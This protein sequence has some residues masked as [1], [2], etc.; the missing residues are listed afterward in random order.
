MGLFS[1]LGTIAGGAIGGPIG[2]KIGGALGGIGGSLLSGGG[3][4]R[5]IEEARRIEAEQIGANIEG[6]GSLRDRI[7]GRTEP[8]ITA[9]QA[10]TGELQRLLI[11]GGRQDPTTAETFATERA[12]EGFARSQ[13]ANKQLLSGRSISGLG[14]IAAGIGSQFRQQG[15]QNL[16]G[17]SGQGLQASGQA[18]SGDII[19]EQSLAAQREK[20]GDIG[21]S[22]TLGRDKVSQGILKGV[23]QSAGNLLDLF[24]P[25]SQP[26]RVKGPG[27]GG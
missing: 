6:F 16:F 17:L 26:A 14:E 9:G 21:S 10:G 3:E 2:A 20:L 18:T 8:A 24:K 13:G 23:G 12:Q 7:L 19:T 15:I 4:K 22:A 1:T 11:G 5:A 25:S 27:P